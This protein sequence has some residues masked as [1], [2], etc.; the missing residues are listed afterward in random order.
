MNNVLIYDTST[1][2]IIC[3]GQIKEWETP[4]DNELLYEN[5]SPDIGGT[6]YVSNGTVLVRTPMPITAAGLVLS[7]VP[8]N[9]TLY[10]ED[11]SYPCN[12]NVTLSFEFP[13]TYP[14]RIECFPYLDFNREIVI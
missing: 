11:T 10:V 5:P 3:V 12:G 9:S 4:A 6:H 7:D 13:G 8:A 1:G 14:I 2:K